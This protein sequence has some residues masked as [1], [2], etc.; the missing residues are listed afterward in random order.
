VSVD[1]DLVD[2]L[3]A[4]VAVELPHGKGRDALMSLRAAKVQRWALLRR[5]YR[6]IQPE[7]TSV[8]VRV[9]WPE[10]V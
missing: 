3:T 4:I 10:V 2:E 7:A 5:E 8:A 6:E 1:D 9:Y